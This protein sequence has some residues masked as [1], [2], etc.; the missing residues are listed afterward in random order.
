MRVLLQQIMRARQPTWLRASCGL[1]MGIYGCTA[2]AVVYRGALDRKSAIVPDAGLP[3]A[4]ALSRDAGAAVFGCRA[5]SGGGSAILNEILARL[6]EDFLTPEKP[7]CTVDADCSQT[8]VTPACDQR[9][10]SCVPCESA[11]QQGA[12][13]ALLATC[14]ATAAGRCCRDPEASPDCLVKACMIACGGT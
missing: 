7:P 4:G 3:Q 6:S 14:L 8:F 5:A 12:F 13:A 11:P 9:T 1:L 2:D 10:G